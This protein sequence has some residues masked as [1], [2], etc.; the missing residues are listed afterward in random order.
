MKFKNAREKARYQLLCSTVRPEVT[1][2]VNCN[3]HNIY[4]EAFCQLLKSINS[5][6]VK[7]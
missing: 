6:T 5:E 2:V 7:R 3:K 1:I 4:H